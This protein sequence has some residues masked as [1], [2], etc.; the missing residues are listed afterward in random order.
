MSPG[1]SPP[2]VR[3]SAG[4]EGR[5]RHPHGDD[6]LATGL[7]GRPVVGAWTGDA[8]EGLTDGGR[9]GI[10]R[11]QD[12]DLDGDLVVVE[13]GRILQMEREGVRGGAAVVRTSQ[14]FPATSLPLAEE[15][16]AHPHQRHAEAS[17][18]GVVA[19]PAIR[20]QG[21]DPKP[22]AV[23]KKI[24]AVPMLSAYAIVCRPA[25]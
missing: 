5:I 22:G 2:S 3:R 25:R 13:P 1:Q 6:L 4:G 7:D 18:V 20:P 16:L 12:V 24:G 11:A 23:A 17:R 21:R 14:L 8:I 10:D 19:R 15:A 9:D